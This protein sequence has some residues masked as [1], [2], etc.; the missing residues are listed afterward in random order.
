MIESPI[1]NT[2]RLDGASYY[3]QQH[4][5]IPTL[6]VEEL[7]T[8]FDDAI[9]AISAASYHFG[10]KP[11]YIFPYSG[12]TDLVYYLFRTVTPS[13][14]IIRKGDFPLYKHV[15]SAL[16]M[17]YQEV[18]IRDSHD[19]V[20]ASFPKQAGTICI[21]SRPHSILGTTTDLACIEDAIRR[22]PGVIFVIDEAYQAFSIEV[23]AITLL[24]K[25]A[26]V[27]CL[28]TASK[29][30]SL[31]AIRL[32]WLLTSNLELLNIL[33]SRS[34]NQIS[35]LSE[36]LVADIV[37]HQRLRHTQNVA[38]VM[39]ERARVERRLQSLKWLGVAVS[40]TCM[41]FIKIAEFLYSDF[42]DRC[43]EAGLQPLFL[44][45]YEVYRDVVEGAGGEE[46]MVRINIWD[47]DVNSQVVGILEGLHSP[48]TVL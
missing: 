29:E 26:N 38:F 31:P 4:W 10:I 8:Y 3:L 17:P 13:N 36:L 25:Y 48:G 28:R 37:L 7:A 27:A 39:N 24:S 32:G 33:Y 43:A 12:L 47:N 30:F 1:R 34:Y 46:Y 15:L 45:D 40:H 5:A 22:N 11:E 19:L 20:D 14:V 23:S 42:R 16:G 6:S 18:T 44:N 2:V 21:F 41:T 35:R 9:T